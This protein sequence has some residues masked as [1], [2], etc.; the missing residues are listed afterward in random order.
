MGTG[1]SNV[2]SGDRRRL[3]FTDLFFM[4]FGG[5][6]PFISLLTFG[7]VMIA[8]V[9]REGAFAMVLATFIVLFNGL[10]VYFLSKRYSRGGGYY[11][12]AYY[13]LTSR[14]GFNTGWNYLIYAISYGGT[15]L[16]GG[17]YVLYTVLS[18]VLPPSF[19]L[20]K[21]WLLALIIMSV[22]SCMVIAGVRVSARY[23]MVMSTVEMISLFSLAVFFLYDSGWHF[24]NPLPHSINP[25]LLAAAVFGLGIPTGYGSIAPLGE[26]AKASDIGKAAVAVLLFGGSLAVFFFYSLGALNFTGNLV[27]YLLSRFGIIGLIILGFIAL[28]DGTLGGVSYILANSRT[29]EAMSGDH[30]FP[31]FLSILRNNRPLY[32]EIFTSG[33]FIAALTLMVYFVGLYNAFVIL[34]ALAGLNN[35]FIHLSANASLVKISMRR[36]RK[37]IVDV[38]VGILAFIIS[39]SVLFYSLPSLN[40][41][42]VY[43][44]FGWI[45][46]G[47][48]TVEGIEIIR[49]HSNE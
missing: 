13:S 6:A 46:L 34:G 9:G 3:S 44:F 35:L 48:F 26:D 42:V 16:T 17:A 23:A 39:L 47:F 20:L 36:L 7:T 29:I 4:S 14:I 43:L 22:A 38:F 31:S 25:T 24:Y 8:L 28:N 45:I 5:Q 21:Q 30:F 32:V 19:P 49:T 37:Y 1:S 11:T 12:Y 27:L 10:V 18:M 33:I 40:K 15:L 2:S 41:Y